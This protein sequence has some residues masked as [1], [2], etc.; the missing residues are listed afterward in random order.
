MMLQQSSFEK[1]K[2]A[3]EAVIKPASRWTLSRYEKGK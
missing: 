1:M 3:S 2:D